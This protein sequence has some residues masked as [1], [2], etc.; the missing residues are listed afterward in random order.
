MQTLPITPYR[1]IL[2]F[3]NPSINSTKPNHLQ[4]F[5]WID[6]QQYLL[7]S[8]EKA[9]KIISL[10][11]FKTKFMGPTFQEDIKGITCYN[12]NVFIAFENRIQKLHLFHV[13]DEIKFDKSQIIFNIQIF[14]KI[15]LVGMNGSLNVYDSDTMTLVN[16]IH[17]GFD[18][19]LIEHP[20]TYK[21]K[22][23]VSD[24]KHIILVN[25]N[26]GKKLFSY[27][28]DQ[29]VHNILQEVRYFHYLTLEQYN[30]YGQQPGQRHNEL[31]IRYWPDSDPEH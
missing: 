7:L 20:L 14:Q 1:S 28:D 18:A 2:S 23:L 31:G 11:Q 17:L 3:G 15:L 9:Y 5:Y 8:T 24:G 25:I 12:E 4:H 21:N 10:P 26:T 30:L 16:Q 19:K 29:T 13:L 6:N 22:V 27:S